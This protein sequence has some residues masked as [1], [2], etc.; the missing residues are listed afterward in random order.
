MFKRVEGGFIF[1]APGLFP[2]HYVV[3]EVQKAEIIQRGMRA[4]FS[5]GPR[6]PLT[7]K[8]LLLSFSLILGLLL[9]ALLLELALQ[10]LWMW[11]NGSD[12]SNSRE[13]TPNWVILIVI[14]LIVPIKG[15]VMT[16]TGQIGRILKGAHHT[17]QRITLRERNK[18]YAL[19]LPLSTLLAAGVACALG[20]ALLAMI[21]FGVTLGS[22]QFGHTPQNQLDQLESWFVLVALAFLA[23]RY[24]YLAILKL[25]LGR[26]A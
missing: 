18:I 19:L 13:I 8:R 2:R 5:S 3:T 11:W 16:R 17:E 14:F 6:P 4:P 9:L 24:F 25:A 22:L 23:A 10:V 15:V 1:R 7:P 26:P 21:A 12:Q 20:C